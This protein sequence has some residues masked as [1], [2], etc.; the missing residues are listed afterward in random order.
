MQN[1][2][3]LAIQRQETRENEEKAKT[4]AKI[5]IRN[6]ELSISPLDFDSALHGNN[7]DQQ[8]Q[9]KPNPHDLENMN[10]S[11]FDVQD[12]ARGDKNNI[13]LQSQNIESP[14]NNISNKGGQRKPGGLNI[15]LTEIKQD[16]FFKQVTFSK[17]N[18]F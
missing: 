10:V 9:L 18:E 3:R 16:E 15:E 14:E 11:S 8:Y 4:A 12:S 7:R 13:M 2:L 17:S 5:F 6:Q 1:W